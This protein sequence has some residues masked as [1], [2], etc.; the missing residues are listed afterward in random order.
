[1]DKEKILVVLVGVSVFLLVI[2]VVAVLWLYP[3][4]DDSSV[5]VVSAG[6]KAEDSRASVD[7]F[8]TIKK[9]EE[10]PGLLEGEEPVGDGF[11]AVDTI[12][13][14]T[15]DN[16]T[17]ISSDVKVSADSASSSERE[18]PSNNVD[19]NKAVASKPSP[20]PRPTVKAAVKPAPTVAPATVS[21]EYW[22]Q[23]ASFTSRSKAETV[24]E[25]LRAKGIVCR[26]LTKTVD[27]TV[28]YRVRLGPYSNKSEA[29]KFLAVVHNIKGYEKSYVSLVYKKS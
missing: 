8:S 2:V 14:E 22:I 19:G 1:M 15:A 23:I 6:A 20:T 24:V 7:L 17:G 3:A 5:S 18:K 25:E 21:K 10:L 26:I 13:G 16:K 27:N 11:I 9:G 12:Y 4:K 29:E 28:Y